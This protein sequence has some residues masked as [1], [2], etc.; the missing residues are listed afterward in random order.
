MADVALF[1]QDAQGLLPAALVQLLADRLTGHRLVLPDVTERTERLRLLGAGVH[2]DHRD[3][4][5]LGL[6]DHV[7]HGA[8]LGE[9]HDQPVDLLVDVGLHQ[10][11]LPLGL[12][13]VPVDELDVVLDGGLLGAVL[14]DVPEGVAVSRVGDHRERPPGGVHRGLAA[15][16]LGG[17]FLFGAQASG[18]AAPRQSHAEH[19]RQHG[20][21]GASP[22]S[23][24]CH[25][26]SPFPLMLPYRLRW[27][28]ALSGPAGP[29]AYGVMHRLRHRSAGPNRPSIRYR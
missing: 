17:A 19:R 18:A 14:D 21:D 26:D 27:F 9:R 22:S 20:A 6:G 7:L 15:R 29:G 23:N 8:G 11:A 28:S 13:V 3:T 2:R 10:L 16:G 5:L 1:V 12:L 4:G 25:E 24:P